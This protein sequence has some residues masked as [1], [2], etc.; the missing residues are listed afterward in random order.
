VKT[1]PARPSNKLS[2]YRSPNG[3]SRIYKDGSRYKL[4]RLIT[5]PDGSTTRITGSGN[6]RAQCETN[7]KALVSK[8][9][10]EFVSGHS[11]TELFADYCQHWLDQVRSLQPIKPKTR[12]GYQGAIDRGIRPY[13]GNIKLTE[14]KRS[15]IQAMY[16]ALT[17]AGKSYYVLKEIRVVLNGALSEAVLSE[18]ISNN[19]ATLVKLP[20]KPM[21]KPTSFT[22]EEVQKIL[23]TAATRGELARWLT[24][25]HLGPRQGERLAWRWEDLDLDTENP[26]VRVRYGL[27][28][29]TGK[30]LVLLTPK[31]ASSVRDLPLTPEIVRVLKEHRKLSNEARLRTGSKWRS[32]EHVFT[33]PDGKPIDPSNDRKAWVALLAEANVPYKSLKTARS[34]TG[35]LMHAAGVD[36]LSVSKVMGHSSISTTAQY[37]VSVSMDTK[38]KA[39][40]ALGNVL[41]AN[42]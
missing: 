8:R 27:Q 39:I 17:Q 26:V 20:P 21:V 6:T 34:T 31:N 4:S 42:E 13:L 12:V 23:N 22:V 37:Y 5:F 30:G 35:T 2:R 11:A 3:E 16:S 18:K 1:T 29:V 41:A 33:T 38:H 32:F 25:L 7:T 24:A 10:S 40:I 36:L 28:R 14:L 15:D 9:Y 19:P